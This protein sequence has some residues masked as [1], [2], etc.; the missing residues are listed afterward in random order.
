MT[1]LQS[2]GATCSEEWRRIEGWP[3]YEIS[4]LGRLGS[5]HKL[6]N[7]KHPPQERR[8]LVG[9]K[10]KDG[11][12][13]AVLVNGKT[14]RSLRLH[15]L[16]LDTFQGK[17]PFPEA[18]A[19]HLNGDLTDNSVTNL[20]WGTQQENIDDRE[21]HGRTRSGAHHWSRRRALSL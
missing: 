16:V 6:P 9:G 15:H 21:R 4:S 7:A 20:C 1:D 13:R 19:R 3:G 18:V 10:D 12:R 17:R 8:I 2:I 5:W 11:Y 14:R